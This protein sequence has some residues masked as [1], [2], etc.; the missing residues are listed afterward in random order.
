M[1]A[2]C[3]FHNLVR[4]TAVVCFLVI[5]HSQTARAVSILNVS[6]DTTLFFDN[7]EGGTVGATPSGGAPGS[8]TVENGGDT[9]QVSDTVPPGAN[10][11][12]Q[13]LHLFQGGTTAANLADF[14]D[15]STAND[16]IRVEFAFQMR[17]AG[18]N[19]FGAVGL[20]DTA[21]DTGYWPDGSGGVFLEDVVALQFN[22]TDTNVEVLVPQLNTAFERSLVTT[23]SIDEWHTGVIDYNL[24]ASTFTAIIDG[25]SFPGL[26]AAVASDLIHGRFATSNT[27]S[28]VYFDALDGPP[29]GPP[30]EFIWD[31]AG[32]GDWNVASNWDKNS[33]PGLPTSM[34]AG[35]ERVF[36][37]DS[38]SSTSTVFTDEDR[39]LNGI[40]FDN[41]AGYVVAGSGEISL[42]NSPDEV[43]PSLEVNSGSHEF[44]AAVA[45]QAD[46]TVNVASG[47]S[48]EFINRLNLNGHALTKIGDG[49]LV[50]SNTLNTG[51]GTLDCV[52][53]LCSGSGT[54]GGDL[55]NSGGTIS[56]GNSS[57]VITVSGR[58]QVPEP[59]TLVLLLIGAI[60]LMRRSL[61]R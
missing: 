4:T 32:G 23:V 7:F 24:G 35:E 12:T 1:I 60:G 15:Q 3:C 8:W 27:N 48:L 13:Y 9:N 54:I 17:D 50:I 45:I 38:V 51:G 30:T 11:G 31:A 58:E 41:A 14:A 6:T 25:I 52:Q 2:N 46:T 53:G 10:Q 44:Q 18:G 29:P 34:V 55:N 5:L 42:V 39:E 22:E 49:N 59:S 36:F 43:G 20:L 28:I 40:Q 21:S 26:E 57:A 47:A 33:V 16:N 61:R 56:P 19:G 37:E